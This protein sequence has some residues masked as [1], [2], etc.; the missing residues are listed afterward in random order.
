MVLCCNTDFDNVS[1]TCLIFLFV[2]SNKFEAI[3]LGL[4]L[5]HAEVNRDL[6]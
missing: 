2:S 6:K 5:V 1:Y 4:D 3:V